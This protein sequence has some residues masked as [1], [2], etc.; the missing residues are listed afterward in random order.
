MS[1][2]VHFQGQPKLPH[3]ESGVMLLEAL[4]G[5]LLFSIGILGLIGM[6]GV[7]ITNTTE[8]RYRSEAAYLANQ[9]IGRMWIDRA[10]LASYA[11]TSSTTSCAAA[12]AAVKNWLC[13]VEGDPTATPPL[14]ATLPGITTAAATRPTITIA[15]DTVTVTL[16]WRVAENA[17]ITDNSDIRKY[18]VIA[19]IN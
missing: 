19:R 2:A 15:T 9:I 17:A 7:A 16:R 4:L 18:V 12:P 14:P 5:I 3:M 11:L 6:Q 10:N 1:R 13:Q 8:A